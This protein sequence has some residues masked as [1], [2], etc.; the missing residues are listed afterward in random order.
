MKHR[1]ISSRAVIAKVYR[2]LKPNSS[3]FEQDAFEW[4]GEVMAFIGT[5][6]TVAEKSEIVE[7]ESYVADLPDDLVSISSVHWALANTLS[8]FQAAPKS[9]LLQNTSRISVARQGATDTGIMSIPGNSYYLHKGDT[10]HFPFETG[11]VLLTYFAFAVDEDGFP[12]VPDNV[13]VLTACFWYIL[14]QMIMGGYK[15]PE[16]KLDYLYADEKWG[17]YCTQARNSLVY[18]DVVEYEAFRRAWVRLIPEDRFKYGF[19]LEDYRSNVGG[20][21]IISY[22]L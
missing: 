20:Y 2:D 1:Q 16:P 22:E 10:L 18:P 3:T 19:S 6:G 7:I 21:G 12:T 9:E 11:F 5:G 4:V 8:E 13:S 15:H 17:Y 14:R